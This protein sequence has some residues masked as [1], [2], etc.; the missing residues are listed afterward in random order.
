[1][2][3]SEIIPYL[4]SGWRIPAILGLILVIGAIIFWAYSG[5]GQKEIDLNRNI[6]VIDGNAQVKEQIA[7]EKAN[8]TNQA[9]NNLNAVLQR[10]SNSFTGN[11]TDKFCGNPAFQCDSTCAD[12][13]LQHGIECR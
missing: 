12:Y 10:D 11:T 5:S 8:I 2:N 13:R 3:K 4:T 1:M 7:N 9:L 6:G